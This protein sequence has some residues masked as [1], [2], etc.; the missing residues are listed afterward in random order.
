MLNNTTKKK[1]M[2]SAW[3]ARIALLI[4]FAWNVHCAL[5]FIIFPQ[6]FL[7]AYEL[8]GVGGLVAI[9]GV[10][11]VFLMWNATYPIV[12]FNPWKY[13]VIFIIIIIQQIIG[14]AGENFIKLT[15]ASESSILR[16]SLMRFVIFDSIGLALMLLAYVL[17]L[18]AY[19]EKNE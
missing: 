14:L 4:V 7:S 10:G 8:S 15:T 6:N 19:R 9:Q 3:F 12:I 16:A 5:V 13:R 2:C 18:I 1:K 17:M 11:V